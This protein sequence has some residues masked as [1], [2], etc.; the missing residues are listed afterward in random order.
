MDFAANGQRPDPNDHNNEDRNARGIVAAAELGGGSFEKSRPPDAGHYRYDP[1]IAI[2]FTTR[3]I[4]QNH[5]SLRIRGSVYEALTRTDEAIADYRN[6]LAQDPFQAESRDALQRL[7]QEVPPEEGQPL[8]P[9][10]SG[11]AFA[12]AVVPMSRICLTSVRSHV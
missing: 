7:D 1:G 8:G 4:F 6:A 10:V 3:A 5:L 9:P 2:E 12:R 11:W